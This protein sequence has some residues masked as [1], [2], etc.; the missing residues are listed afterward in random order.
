MP[1]AEP[2]FDPGSNLDVGT[3]RSNFEPGSN[4]PILALIPVKRG[5]GRPRK[6][7]P[8]VIAYIQDPIEQ[9]DTDEID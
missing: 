8:E 2:N 6:V 7:R 3:G 4:L 1:D 9:F 5:R